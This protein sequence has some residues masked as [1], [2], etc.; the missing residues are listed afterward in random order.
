MRLT[1][2]LKEIV[3]ELCRGFVVG[4]SLSCVRNSLR[5]PSLVEFGLTPTIAG[6]KGNYRFTTCCNHQP[7]NRFDARGTDSDT[8]GSGCGNKGSH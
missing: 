5:C 6:L 7:M 4:V 2:G 1:F 8:I 3:D